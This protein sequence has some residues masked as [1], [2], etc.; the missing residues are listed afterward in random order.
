[1]E[2]AYTAYTETCTL[3]LDSE[4]I[5]R[6]V[7]AVQKPAGRGGARPTRIPTSAE[8]CLGAQYVATL[9]LSVPGGMGKVPAPGSQM[10]F[11]RVEKN[12][13]ISLVRSAPIVRFEP[14]E[15][16]VESQTQ[17]RR[18]SEAPPPKREVRSSLLPRIEEPQAQAQRGMTV[19]PT[20]PL[21][22]L[23]QAD[24]MALSGRMSSI[25][26]SPARDR[27]PRHVPAVHY[28]DDD[29]LT[30]PF[31]NTPTERGCLLVNEASA[32]QRL[33]ALERPNE[34]SRSSSAPAPPHR[35]S[36]VV[37]AGTAARVTIP[38]PPPAAR[39]SPDSG[40]RPSYAPPPS[41]SPPS[42][43]WNG[44]APPPSPKRPNIVRVSAPFVEAATQPRKRSAR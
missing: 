26:P 31:E 12:G 28:G 5:C 13:R 9:D 32:L 2:I 44:E 43:R 20:P 39:E 30:I 16:P 41:F 37:P 1:M 14:V 33:S 18:P 36:G 27:G 21:P 10:L 4:G 7:V 38:P 35:N 6:S 25:P 8:K 34:G 17:V 24:A 19:P 11:A 40:R 15:A 23:P 29:E 42:Q 22:F 3:L